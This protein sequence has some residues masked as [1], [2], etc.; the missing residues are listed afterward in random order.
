MIKNSRLL[1]IHGS[2][3]SGQ[4]YKARLLCAR[5]PGMLA[6]DF[7]DDLDERLAKLRTLL[8]ETDGWV[9]IGSSLGGLAAA[10]YAAQHPGQVRKLVLLAPA[11]ALPQFDPYRSRRINVPTVILHGTLD[12]VV[13]LES[14]RPIA[15]RVFPNLSYHVVE[16]DH[17]LHKAAEGLDWEGI[18]G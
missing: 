17:R 4:T 18:L 13:P 12:E 10:L 15:E 9:L 6:P 16:D 1:F 5:F 2:E 14:V 8:G 3:S 11:L 7:S